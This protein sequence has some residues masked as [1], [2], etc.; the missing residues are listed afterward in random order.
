MSTTPEAMENVANAPK[1]FMKGRFN[2]YHTT[3]GGIHITYQE[4]N[5]EEVR[6]MDIPGQL[7]RAAEMMANGEM[8][9]S[10]AMGT[11]FSLFRGL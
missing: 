8:S 1:P 4:D 11:V 5:S 6:H 9:A 10:K 2:L 3:G 7:I